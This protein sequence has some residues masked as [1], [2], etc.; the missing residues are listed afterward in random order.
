MPE[1]RLS[2]K[3]NSRPTQ[4]PS[5]KK[6]KL[7]KARRNTL[8]FIQS[9]WSFYL[10]PLDRPPPL[11]IL[12]F[13]DTLPEQITLISPPK[14]SVN[15][16]STA[17]SSSHINPLPSSPTFC[18]TF[19]LLQPQEGP[20]LGQSAPVSSHMG[21]GVPGAGREL[22]DDCKSKICPRLQNPQLYR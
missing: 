20:A 8:L 11:S 9:V 1:Q 13:C 19:P 2:I 15:F 22:A 17:Q 14:R 21:H 6:Q 7:R 3:V 16:T 18:S 5:L 4:T 10:L 12:S